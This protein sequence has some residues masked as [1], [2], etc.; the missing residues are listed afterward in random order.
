MPSTAASAPPSHG[1]ARVRAYWAAGGQ[2]PGE[3]TAW[4]AALL[5]RHRRPG[6]VVDVGCGPGESSVA[7]AVGLDGDA[8]VLARAAARGVV[9]V[10]ADVERPWPLADD[11]AGTVVLF[12]V[13]EHVPDPLALLSEA[14]RVLRRDGVLLVALPNAAHAVNRVAALR[15]RTDDFTDAA[16]RVGAPVSDHL[17]R[18]TLA[19][20]AALLAA[21]GFTVSARHDFFPSRFTDGEWRRLGRLAGLLRASGAVARWPGLLAYEVCY[22]CRPAAPEPSPAPVPA[23]VAGGWGE[24]DPRYRGYL[25]SGRGVRLDHRVRVALDLLQPC[26]GGRLVDVGAG[27]GWITAQA[28][29]RVGAAEAVAVDVAAPP[30]LAPLARPVE[31]V[32]V[33]AGAPLPFADGT[34]DTVL[35][36]ETIEHLLDPDALLA[37]LRRLLV[38][39]GQLVLST[40][41]L[42]S[43][44]V[45][46]ALAAGI[47]PPGVDASARR[48]Y[49]TPLGE[50]RPSGHLHLFTR[51]A[52]A[53]ALDAH[54]F[55]VDRYA[56]ARFSSSWRQARRATRARTGADL[57]LDA[58]FALYDLVPWRKDVQVVRAVRR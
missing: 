44:L 15:G 53:E 6:A 52:L 16:H 58:A 12:D 8:D 25:P 17:H 31:H 35:C 24:D 11:S 33:P 50:G 27:D 14:A 20:G 29:L 51:R 9:P 43:G 41:R 47:Q 39:G 13:L 32:A 34:A 48:R 19:S 21:S 42:D 56:E 2:T 28:A 40:P 5:A 4:K 55:T 36:L 37:E 38:P 57:L 45:I 1:V 10:L 3:Q 7:G 46:A 22:V 49:G 23:P 30:P 54:G 18:F 26:P